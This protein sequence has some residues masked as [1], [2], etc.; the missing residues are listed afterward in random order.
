MVMG[1]LLGVALAATPV[2]LDEV[3]TQSRDNLESL[4]AALNAER[5]VLRQTQARSGLL[6]QVSAFASGGIQYNGPREEYYT[7][8]DGSVSPLQIE[9]SM[10]A[11]MSLGVSVR[12]LIYDGAVWAQLSAAG[13]TAEAAKGEAK[14]QMDASELEG[15]RRFF[16]LFRAQETLKVMRESVVRSEQQVTIAESLYT[17]GRGP[18]SDVL[19]ARINLGNDRIGVINQRSAIANAQAD[20]AS[21]LRMKGTTELVAQ[22]PGDSPIPSATVGIDEA[23]QT[24]EAN[25]PMLVSLQQRVKAAEALRSQ[26][27]AAFTPRVGL[28][29]QYNRSAPYADLFFTRWGLQNSVSAGLQIDWDLFNGFRDSAGVDLASRDVIEA[30]ATYAQTRR[31]IEADIRKAWMAVSLLQEAEVISEANRDTAREALAALNERFRAGLAT[32]LEVRDSELK[33]TQAELTLVQSRLDVEV[34]K[35]TLERVIGTLSGGKRS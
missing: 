21:W 4:R 7:S 2:T 30:E 14:E 32:Q 11:A 15:I 23:V 25:R 24:A 22:D 29:G 35:A 31:D 3:R 18:Q 33:V 5:A 10:Y 17:A 6:P 1:V 20:L 34:A 12:Q 19:N 8:P 16:D 13:S 9:E 26:A 27:R 28:Y